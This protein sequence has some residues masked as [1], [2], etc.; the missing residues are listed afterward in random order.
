MRRPGGQNYLRKSSVW[1]ARDLVNYIVDENLQEGT[2]LPTEREMQISFGCGRTTIRE[3]LRILEMR[4]VITMR[5]GRGGGPVVRKPKRTDLG[6]ALQL[7]LLFESATLSDIIEA[8]LMLEPQVAE[9]A[10]TTMGADAREALQQTVDS[11]LAAPD[12]EARFSSE[13]SRFH[14]LIVTA[15]DKPVIA[16]FQDSLKH[17]HDGV[18]LGVHYDAQRVLAIARA[19]QRIIDRLEARDPAGSS[20]A[21]RKHL[22][23]AKKYWA[24]EYPHMYSKPLRWLGD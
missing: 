14:S 11:M 1:L 19:H 8:R 10:A 13:N 6:E 24:T 7:I 23:E 21:M 4:G 18:G 9:M 16:V 5:A 15:I 2:M 12:D 22:I 20:A 17:V 3:A